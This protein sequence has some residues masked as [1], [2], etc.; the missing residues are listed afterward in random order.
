MVEGSLQAAYRYC[1]EL[2]RREARN[3]YYGFVLLPLAKRQAVYA[4]YA[5]ARRCDDIVDADL[6]PAE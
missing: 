4:V 2:A 5:F 6:E 1:Q 3:F